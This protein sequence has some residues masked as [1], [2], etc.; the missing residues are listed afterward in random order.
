MTTTQDSLLI[1]DIN[2]DLLLLKDGSATLVLKV[3]AVNFGL[4][5]P[6][7]QLAIID[8]FA[9]LLNSLSFSIQI[10]IQSIKLD[11]SS[12][13]TLLD[14]AQKLQNNPLLSAMMSRYRNF[15]QQTIKENEVLDKNFYITI[16]VSSLELGLSLKSNPLSQ[17]PKIKA[18]IWPRRDQLIRQLSRVGIK[19]EQLKDAQLVKLFFGIYNQTINSK[20]VAP[21]QVSPVKLAAPKPTAPPPFQPAP[22]TIPFT[23][24]APAGLSSNLA[25]KS[26]PFVVEELGDNV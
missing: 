10:I 21:V 13:L 26:H 25:R 8:N 6:K 15:V 9:Q 1:Q 24:I 17:L 11:I 20:V 3:G 16:N 4:L 5:S 19:A 18:I 22:A 2:S 7:E 23:P 12:Y 14:N